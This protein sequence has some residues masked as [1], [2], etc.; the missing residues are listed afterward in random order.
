MTAAHKILDSTDWSEFSVLSGPATEYSTWLRRFID[1]DGPEQVQEIWRHIENSVFAQGGLFTA[2]EPSI[3]V[4]LASLIDERPEIVVLYSLDL[5]FHLSQPAVFGKDQLAERCLHEIEAG[6]WL[7][8]RTALTGSE[9][10]R[11]AC[12]EVLDL[13]SPTRASLVRTVSDS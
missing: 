13:C 10:V 6:V 7:L 9:N 4:L 5:L 12:L 1:A 11:S 3:Q 8:V 2:A